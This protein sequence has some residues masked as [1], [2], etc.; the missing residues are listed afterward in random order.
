MEELGLSV[1][2]YSFFTS[3]MTLGGMITAVFS[4]KISALV[5]RRQ[6]MWIS[7]VCCIFGWLAVAFAHDII[8]LNTGRLFLGFGVGLISYV[9]PV[10]IAEITPKTFRGGFS[11][12]NQLLQCLGISLMFFT[13]NFFHWRTLALLSNHIFLI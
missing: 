7:D 9:V 12:S 2:D 4:G 8:M 6:T 5:G 13:G 1:A 11:Y 10:Y 3:V